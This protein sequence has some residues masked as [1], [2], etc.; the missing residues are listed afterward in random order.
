[1]SRRALK[2]SITRYKN[3]EQHYCL[4]AAHYYEVIINYLGPPRGTACLRPTWG[5]QGG[6]LDSQDIVPDAL[7]KVRKWQEVTVGGDV[8][9]KIGLDL[10][11]QHVVREREHAAVK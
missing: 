9:A 10:V 6:L 3:I 8:D 11:P 5:H 2:I 7:L 1:M 4:A